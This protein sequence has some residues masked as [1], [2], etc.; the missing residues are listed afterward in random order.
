MKHKQL[1]I[2]TFVL[3]CIYT[4]ICA[5]ES[6]QIHCSKR[7]MHFGGTSVNVT[8]VIKFKTDRG[9]IAAGHNDSAWKKSPIATG[10]ET[11]GT[12]ELVDIFL[13]VKHTQRIL[14]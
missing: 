11:A 12:V 10:Y 6:L 7:A 9:T 5:K 4:K 1:F 3:T 2:K 13:L 8:D 14:I